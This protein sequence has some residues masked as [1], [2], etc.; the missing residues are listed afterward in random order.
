MGEVILFN[1]EPQWMCEWMGQNLHSES[2]PIQRG[3]AVNAKDSGTGQL[4][5]KSRPKV[6]LGE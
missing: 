1:K 3:T 2:T 5:H 4:Q 6:E